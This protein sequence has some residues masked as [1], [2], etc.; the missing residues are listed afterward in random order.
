MAG[1]CLLAKAQS[2]S[3]QPILF[4]TPDGQSV[5]NALL[6]AAQAPGTPEGL[7]NT[8]D[9]QPGSIFSSPQFGQGMPVPQPV[10]TRR[11]KPQDESD[12]RKSMGMQTPA[13]AMGV[14]S[15]RELFGLP[16]SKTT[17][18]MPQYD[19][20][21]NTNTLSSD[22]TEASDANWSKILSADSDAFSTAKTADSNSLTGA[23]YDNAPGDSLFRDKKSGDEKAGDDFDTSLSGQVNGRQP[24]QPIW[25]AAIQI[26]G[27]ANHPGYSPNAA[28]APTSLG[29]SSFNS[30][31]PFALPKISA[32]ESTMPHLPTLPGVAGQSPPGPPVNPTPSWAP[33]PP[34]WVDTG[35]AHGVM[36]QRKF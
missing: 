35:P 8:P 1:F 36:P 9:A 24:G 13:E 2:A 30:Q 26:A 22:G 6:P 21:G 34:P 33:K 14:P 18:S 31:S 32:P 11:N 23:F 4:S 28:P 15:M 29:A 5:S 27:P 16:K 7:A 12:I 17:N 25:E 3:E 20:A 10:V 19:R